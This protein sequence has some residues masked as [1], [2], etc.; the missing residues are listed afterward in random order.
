MLLRLLPLLPLVLRLPYEIELLLFR[1]TEELAEA[2][3]E[4][5]YIEDTVLLVFWNEAVDELT[6]A[7]QRVKNGAPLVFK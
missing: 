6:P 3:L 2:L 5:R 4:L 1:Y 7:F